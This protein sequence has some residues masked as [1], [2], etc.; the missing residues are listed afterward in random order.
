MCIRDR[1]MAVCVTD[2]VQGLLMLAGVVTIPIIAFFLVGAGNVMD[3]ITASGV[4]A[5]HYL[6]IFNDEKGQTLS[7]IDIISKLG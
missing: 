4:E 2:F 6:N 1:F 7:A 3:N 5:H